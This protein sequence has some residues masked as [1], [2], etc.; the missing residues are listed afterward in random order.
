MDVMQEGLQ[1]GLQVEMATRYRSVCIKDFSSDP[2][3]HVMETRSIQPGKGCFSDPV[4]SLK[5]LCISPLFSNRSSSKESTSR[6]SINSISNTSLANTILV[7]KTAPN[8]YQGPNLTTSENRSAQGAKQGVSSSGRKKKTKTCGL[9]SLREKL[10][11]EGISKR[12]SDLITGSRRESSLSHYESSWG[13]FSSWCSGRKTDPFRSSLN[14]VLEFLAHLFEEGLE[15]NTIAGYR[16]AISAFH[17]PIEGLSLGDNP[18]V[19]ALMKGVFNKRPPKPRYMFIW[20]VQKVLEYLGSLNSEKITNKL[21]TIKLTLLLALTSASRAHEI[22]YLDTNYLIKHSSCY[23]FHFEK[24]TKTAK[25]GNSRPVIKFEHFLDKNLCV[26]HHID[27]YL[28]RSKSWRKEET[29]LL[30]SF[31]KP[32]KAV[33]TASVSR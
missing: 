3:L 24:L 2:K 11:S 4:D 5:G 15:Y 26:C 31:I 29:Q 27:L 17:D 12:A 1:S 20:D 28:E 6:E 8:I 30:I 7:P 21:L 25:P 23:T 32:H 18:R 14:Y 19:S 16:S 22:C 33:T 13:K 10:A 9:D